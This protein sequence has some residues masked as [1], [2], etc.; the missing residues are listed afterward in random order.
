M[1]VQA[2]VNVEQRALPLRR[3]KAEPQGASRTQVKWTNAHLPQGCQDVNRW[4]RVFVP[5]YIRFVASYDNPWTVRDE[6]SVSAMQAIWNK[7]YGSK[8]EHEIV[9]QQA[10]HS[11]V[12]S[13]INISVGC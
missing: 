9:A 3:I 5:T 8:I 10:V 13:F 7:V 1:F 6:D 2:L 4:R 11:V 12:R